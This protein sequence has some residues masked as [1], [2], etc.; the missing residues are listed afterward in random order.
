MARQV[1]S[2]STTHRRRA[3]F[4]AALVTGLALAVQTALAVDVK[5]GFEKTFDF[6]RA[7]TWG[8]HPDGAGEVKMARTA[9]DDA[10][11]MKKVADPVITAAVMM[12]MERR[13]LRYQPDNPDVSVHYYLLL[14]TGTSAQEMGQFLPAVAS[15]GLPVFAP[16]T[17]SLEVMNQ[18]SLVLDLSAARNVVWRGVARAKLKFGEQPARR[19][20]LLRE[21]VR[22][23]LKK[24]P[25]KS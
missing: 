20:A 7:Q 9:D 25:P 16:A 2:R 3:P 13:G 18:G 24:F 19:E 14:T 23:L 17:Q 10:A 4:I 8:W 22:D 6:A 11:A 12:E 5:V 21:A 15:W 1:T